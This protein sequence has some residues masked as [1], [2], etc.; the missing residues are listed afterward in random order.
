MSSTACVITEVRVVA[1]CQNV[2]D[3]WLLFNDDK[4]KVCSAADVMSS[5]AYLLFY[6][7]VPAGPAAPKT[8]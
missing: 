5:Q 1:G 8:Q 6:L 3:V 4:V 7:A 2:A